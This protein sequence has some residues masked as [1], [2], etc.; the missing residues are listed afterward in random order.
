MFR[1]QHNF[2]ASSSDHVLNIPNC[3]ILLCHFLYKECPSPFSS[4]KTPIH[5]SRPR[6]NITISMKPSLITPGLMT[7]SHSMDFP[8]LKQTSTEPSP[9]PRKLSLLDCV[10]L[11]DMVHVCFSGAYQTACIQEVLNDC[12]INLVA[13][14]RNKKANLGFYG[15]QPLSKFL[16]NLHLKETISLIFKT[17][18]SLI[19]TWENKTIRPCLPSAQ[20]QRDPDLLGGARVCSHNQ[21]IR[22]GTSCDSGLTNGVASV[23]SHRLG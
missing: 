22:R 20:A 10:V 21:I 9:L 18:A 11:K 8:L 19:T 7:D 12:F 15:H 4:W 17:R 2:P 1:P 6:S 16:W 14:L 3:F 13:T 5:V 23:S